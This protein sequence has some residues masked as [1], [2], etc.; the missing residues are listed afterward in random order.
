MPGGD[1][2]A[3]SPLKDIAKGLYYLEGG[4]QLVLG[5][6]VAL[7]LRVGIG[8]AS[9]GDWLDRGCKAE[10]GSCTVLDLG[11]GVD[12]EVRILPPSAP[13][14]PWLGLG[15]SIEDLALSESTGAGSS[16]ASFRGS[17]TELSA[18]ADVKLGPVAYVGPFLSYRFGQYTSISND[19]SGALLDVAKPA[20][21]D[22]LMIGLRGRY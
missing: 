6:R 3:G 16:S 2:A 7:G 5:K 8:I 17:D 13:V 11:L 21:H 19:D 18:G 10:G 12:A 14:N 22:W 15:F 9:V 4:P 1:V 20:S